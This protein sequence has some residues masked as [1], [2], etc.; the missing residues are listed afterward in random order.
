MDISA[1]VVS[2]SIVNFNF[3]RVKQEKVK[4][5][6]NL[7]GVYMKG[8][9][10]TQNQEHNY[11]LPLDTAIVFI[12]S[13]G[14]YPEPHECFSIPDDDLLENIYK[15]NQTS[16][17]VCS[18]VEN[19]DY[20]SYINDIKDLFEV[21]P[22]FSE[23]DDLD[24]FVKTIRDNFDEFD[25]TRQKHQSNDKD[26]KELKKTDNDVILFANNMHKLWSIQHIGK[27]DFHK[28]Y[29]D[30]N[31]IHDP[32]DEKSNEY[33]DKIHLIYWKADK[34]SNNKYSLISEEIFEKEGKP[35][36]GNWEFVKLSTLLEN[37][38]KRKKFKNIIIIDY[39]CNV[40]DTTKHD[41][42]KNRRQSRSTDELCT[43]RNNIILGKS[44]KRKF[45]SNTSEEVAKY[46]GGKKRR[47]R[48]KRTRKTKKKRKKNVVLN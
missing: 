36:T 43:R 35:D 29:L 37:L 22:D 5:F 38:M 28:N 21:Q 6:L 42:R 16:P 30:K 14:G 48:K 41:I 44:R 26:I 34:G 33:M 12:T 19:Y 39:T 23:P 40:I 32:T 9:N 2:L 1:N 24:V 8:G 27:S 47:T 25:Y 13:H 3:Q 15:I 18:F 31:F 11:N 10:I 20:E 17:G 4:D 45:E 46:W 7:K